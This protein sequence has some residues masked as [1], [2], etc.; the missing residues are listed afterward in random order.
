MGKAARQAREYAAM[1]ARA[2]R[3]MQWARAASL[4]GRADGV[5]GRSPMG[6]MDFMG[7][8]ELYPTYRAGLNE[9]AAERASIAEIAAS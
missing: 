9:G 8:E 5:S 2:E 6:P 3:S 7:Q 1:A 4:Q